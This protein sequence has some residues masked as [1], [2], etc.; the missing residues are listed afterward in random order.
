MNNIL[1]VTKYQ[2][3]DLRMALI[4]FYS[5]VLVLSFLI[6]SAM[7]FNNQID[8]EIR[9]GG[10][11]ASTVIFIFISG[12]NLF[13][14]NFKF[15]L[16]NN[17]SRKR[18]YI[19]TIVTLISVSAFMAVIE[20]IINNSFKVIAPYFSL[21][22]QL[23]RNDFFFAD[24]LWSF[25]LYFFVANLGWIITM[26]YYKLNKL[27]KTVIS[28]LPI[29]IVVLITAINNLTGGVVGKAIINFFGT[30]L[31]FNDNYNS[32]TAML[33]FLIGAAVLSVFSFILIRKM[34]IRD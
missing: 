9:F 15:M 18:F 25:A 30:A 23:Y 5:I 27:M 26:L 29:F 8:G 10:F 33:S 11:G 14:S 4:I 6:I 16:I 32:Y 20:V 2:L 22:E 13:K 28:L 31:G 12:L 21:F 24:F 1:K 7:N 34:P 17:V 19:S 3:R